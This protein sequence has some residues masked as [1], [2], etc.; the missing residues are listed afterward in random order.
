MGFM[1]NLEKSR[2]IKSTETAPAQDQPETSGIETEKEDK[3]KIS[4]LELTNRLN[5]IN[6]QN[7]SVL[8][9]FAHNRYDRTIS[10]KAL[11]QPCINKN[12]VC[13]WPDEGQFQKLSSSYSFRNLTI[14]DGQK[15]I[16]V[17][18][19]PRMISNKGICLTLP[20]AG[21]E[22]RD[23]QIQRHTCNGLKIQLIQNGVFFS[24]TL[25]DFSAISFR[26]SLKADPPQTFQ[27]INPK[28]KVNIIFSNAEE[29]LY[30]GECRIMKQTSGQME[31]EFVL[32]PLS[33]VIQRFKPKEYRSK[34][35]VLTPSP[36][37]I[38][39]HPI[40]QRLLNLKVIDI[41]GSG[42]SVEDNQSNA[43]LMAGMVIPSLELNL[44]NSFRVKC[45]AQVVYRKVQDEEKDGNFVKCGLTFLD[46]DLNDHRRL[47]SLLHQAGNQNSYIS[48]KVDQD[49]L[50]KFFFET[51]FIYPGKYSFIS[52][53]KEKIKKTYK[54]L[55]MENPSIATHFIC[56]RKGIIQG[57]MS[58][59]KFYEN[60]WLIHHHA[61]LKSS[62]I[63]A[64]LVV[65]DQIGK[66]SYD[67]HR[68]YSSH[69]G[70]LICYYRP[71]NK[72]PNQIFGGAVK[73]AENPKAF[74]LDLFSYTHFRKSVNTDNSLP[75]SWCLE[76]PLLVDFQ[77]LESFY[78]RESGGLMLKALDL[79]PRAVDRFDLSGEYTKLGFKRERHLFVL[80]RMEIL[81]A[82]LMLNTTDIA[83][84]MSDLTNC[85]KIIILD[86]ESLTKDLIFKVVS[87]LSKYFEQKKF[88]VLIY[89]S[90]FVEEEKI[91]FEKMYNLWTMNTQYSDEYFKHVGRMLKIQPA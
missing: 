64:G 23:R 51:G 61:A 89:P 77:E 69:M 59:L 60:T 15:M 65:L 79:E 19:S 32:E 80:K 34:R 5:Y 6:F 86:P 63:K 29:N 49:D 40:I 36:D 67:S 45:K 74:S 54:K 88:P 20:E 16:S 3:K 66:F 83:L 28:S 39:D 27:W 22:T 44:A 17:D 84:N 2:E 68:L 9:H 82:V 31:R 18:A 56:Q 58:M 57:H 24:G 7:R 76:K 30:S 10:L 21:I 47:L 4:R 48:S 43:A 50:W 70:Y 35:L 13:L 38:F 71:E 85:I 33:Q 37:M 53:N 52:E 91:P 87:L 41:S 14:P 12:L 11:P 73:S 62:M 46:M 26:I 81:K 72:F 78:E 90:S 25:I 1:D 75:K 42:F 8:I 55:Y